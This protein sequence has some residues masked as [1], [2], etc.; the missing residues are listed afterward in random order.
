[1]GEQQDNEP[2]VVTG[3]TGF[4]GVAL[5]QLLLTKGYAPARVPACAPPLVHRSPFLLA[6]LETVL[7][8]AP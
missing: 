6:R 2:F 4:L 5:V 3:G 1:M 8:A 7:H